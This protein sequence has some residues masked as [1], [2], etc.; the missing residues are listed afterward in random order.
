MNAREA[1]QAL[2]DGKT[3]Y[4]QIGEDGIRHELKLADDGVLMVWY[5]FDQ[6]WQHVPWSL[7]N[8]DGIVEEYPL[9]FEEAIRAMLDG[10]VVKC[11]SSLSLRSCRFHDGVF[12]FHCYDSEWVPLSWFEEK[13]QKSK[14]KVVE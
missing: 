4:H 11:E 14:W 3:V 8:M 6:N 12:Q 13:A 7:N 9:T 5:S 1:M 2:L 10:K